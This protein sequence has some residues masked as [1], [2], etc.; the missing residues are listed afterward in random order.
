MF[1]FGLNSTLSDSDIS[2]TSNLN[3]LA[4]AFKSM[5]YMQAAL[6]V[7]YCNS[8]TNAM[9][10]LTSTRESFDGKSMAAKDAKETERNI[11]AKGDE[12][13]ELLFKACST[14]YSEQL[15]ALHHIPERLLVPGTPKVLISDKE[16]LHKLGLEENKLVRS[17]SNP[18]LLNQAV[19]SCNQCD[20]IDTID[21]DFGIEESSFKVDARH[22]SSTSAFTSTNPVNELITGGKKKSLIKSLKQ[23]MVLTIT[24]SE[25]LQLKNEPE[26][27][28]TILLAAL[29]LLLSALTHISDSLASGNSSASMSYNT[30]NNSIST[31]GPMSQS[32]SGIA[33]DK[34]PLQFDDAVLTEFDKMLSQKL[35][36]AEGSGLY[37]KQRKIPGNDIWLFPPDDKGHIALEQVLKRI[38]NAVLV[39][40]QGQLISY[41]AQI[42]RRLGSVHNTLKTI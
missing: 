18:A 26:D 2:Q 9:S 3:Q 29:P 30:S 40:E 37:I 35:S 4:K 23:F 6:G 7:T 39:M 28:K 12:H 15:S 16:T 13:L 11:S 5:D 38:I 17:S 42:L 34:K 36:A 24:F 8:P 1:L 25:V 10:A 21:S 22:A 20:T 27:A 31:A 19:N 33:A 41:V 14:Q 32:I